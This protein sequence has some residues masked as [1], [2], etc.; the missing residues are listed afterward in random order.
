MREEMGLETLMLSEPSYTSS[1]TLEMNRPSFFL[2]VDGPYGIECSLF[3]YWRR[4]QGGSTIRLSG[5]GG[6]KNEYNQ[7]GE[8]HRKSMILAGYLPF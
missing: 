8:T 5:W 1:R 4:R 7:T 2:I 6:G 3:G